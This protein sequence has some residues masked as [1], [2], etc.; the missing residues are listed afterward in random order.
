MNFKT[1]EFQK[2][3][4]YYTFHVFV[5]IC[6]N[7]TICIFKDFI[8]D[9]Y[10]VS[11]S[12]KLCF[13]K[14]C[15]LLLIYVYNVL[16]FIFIYLSFIQTW[17]LIFLINIKWFEAV[18]WVHCLEFSIDAQMKKQSLNESLFVFNLIQIKFVSVLAKY[19]I[20]ST[21]QFTH[22]VF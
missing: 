10:A 12:S 14:K 17:I 13:R 1:M 4:D 6:K 21:F 7:I 19:F 20:V 5:M 8:I 15:H 9:F 16:F 22:F 2:K 18:H 11:N 3:R